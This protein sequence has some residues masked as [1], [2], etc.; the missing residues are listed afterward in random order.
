MV[1][2]LFIHVIENMCDFLLWNTKGKIQ[3]SLFSIQVQCIKKWNL[4]K[5]NKS[6]IKLAIHYILHYSLLKPYSR[7]FVWN[8]SHYSTVVNIICDF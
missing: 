6:V 5:Y 1:I 3:F 8:L 2:L 4:K 7:F